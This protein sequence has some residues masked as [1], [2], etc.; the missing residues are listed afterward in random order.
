MLDLASFNS[1]RHEPSVANKAIRLERNLAEPALSRSAVTK[2]ARMLL[3]RAGDPGGGLKLTSTGNLSRAVVTEMVKIIEWP[4][5]DK[6]E[7]LQFHKVINEPDFFPVHFVRVLL[8]ATKLVRA[9]R[10]RLVL[11]RLG[12]KML[13]PEHYG[14]LHD[15]RAASSRL[16]ATACRLSSK[17]WEAAGAAALGR[18]MITCRCKGHSQPYGQTYLK[19]V[20]SNQWQGGEAGAMIDQLLREVA[21]GDQCILKELPGQPCC[22]WARSYRPPR[23]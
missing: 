20:D 5:L 7:L 3:G 14:A 11:T 19:H 21:G 17:L 22:C 9:Q 10:D 16:T 2:V 4:G 8:Q 12:K 1:L 6:T 18:T 13:A 23:R 15:T